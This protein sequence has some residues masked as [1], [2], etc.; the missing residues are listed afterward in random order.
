VSDRQRAHGPPTDPVLIKRARI[1]RLAALGQR[2][3]YSLFGVAMVL[4]IIG[5]VTEYSSLLVTLIV[6][7]LIAG[8][9]VLAPAIV[10]GY[11]V[12]AAER[13]GL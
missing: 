1:A 10:A 5:Y 12:K 8:S 7:C 13:E 6:I 4:F 3:G 2:I 11:G 9:A